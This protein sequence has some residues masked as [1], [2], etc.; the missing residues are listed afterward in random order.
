[1]TS[2][3]L[4]YET[5]T[6]I[7]LAKLIAQRDSL[8][9]RVVTR[10][11]NQRLYRT[12]W[13]VLKDRPDAE[14]A[15]QEG[16]LKGF[17]AIDSFAGVSSLS[18]WLTRIVLNEA[19]GRRRSAQ[20]RIRLLREHSIALLDD[21]RENLMGGPAASSSPE[22]DAARGQLAKLIEQAI[23]DLPEAFR[24]VFM[25]REVEGF[26]RRGNCRSL[27]GSCA[28]REDPPPAGAATLAG[29]P[30]SHLAGRSEWRVPLCR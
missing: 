26:E 29:G 6:D 18:T 24:I 16:Y 8:A 15:V 30:R 7:E 27:A 19:L 4:D 22:A 5:L 14:E 20:R 13:S 17:A 25:L 12:A 28:N 3:A 1:M 23:A 2:V 10:R 11:N 21:Y 9:V